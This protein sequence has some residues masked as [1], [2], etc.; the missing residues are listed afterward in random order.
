MRR[1]AANG[2]AAGTRQ[3]YVVHGGHIDQ[4]ARLLEFQAAHPDVEIKKEDRYWSAH[5]DS[6][7]GRKN[8]Y[9]A[10][11]EWLLDMLDEQ[12]QEAVA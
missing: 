11:L 1:A 12:F 6:P 8:A 4:V 10:E 5:W 3:F 9:A 2:S 7:T